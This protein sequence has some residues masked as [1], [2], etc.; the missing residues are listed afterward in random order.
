LTLS[1]NGINTAPSDRELRYGTVTQLKNIQEPKPHKILKNIYRTLPAL[2]A[3]SFEQGAVRR[4]EPVGQMLAS[5]TVTFQN[6]YQN[7][8]VYKSPHFLSY[9]T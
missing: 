8:G 2:L 1:W 7:H 3:I 5:M 6:P 4:R 9:V